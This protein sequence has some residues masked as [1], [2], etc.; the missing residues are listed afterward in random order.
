MKHWR[1]GDAG[2]TIFGPPNGTPTPE[3]IAIVHKGNK[4]NARLL[5]A[6]PDL[7]EIAKAY[8]D[9][10]KSKPYLTITDHYH[11]IESVINKAEGK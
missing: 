9:L 2:N 10:L 5:A 6:A 7:L 8:R 3:I 4:A 1:V 11:H